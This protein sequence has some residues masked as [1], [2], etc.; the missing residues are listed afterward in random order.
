MDNKT[1]M[2]CTGIFL[3]DAILSEIDQYMK[4][5]EHP[6]SQLIAV[7]H[8]VQI[9]FGYLPETV[10]DEIA[11]R[12]QVPAATVSGVAS[13][14][15]FFRLNPPGRHSISVCLGTACFVKGADKILEAFQAE[16]GIS[17]GETSS[18]G[19]F[20][21]D[22]SRCL[23]ICALAPVVQIDDQV[24]SQVKPNQV[25]QIISKIREKEND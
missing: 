14:Y 22:I 15:H 13:F 12:M 3:P 19:E 11:Q 7:L 23:G 16:L 5:D 21:L 25:S 9:H 8:A 20:S 1:V 6:E 24:Y 4:H 18:D 2:E 17:L 10:L